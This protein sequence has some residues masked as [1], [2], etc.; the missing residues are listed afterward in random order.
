[1]KW[2]FRAIGLILF[3]FIAL[4]VAGFFMPAQQTIERSIQIDAYAEDIFPYINDLRNYAQWSPLSDVIINAQTIYGGADAGIGQSMAWQGGEGPFPYG[5]QEIIQSQTGDFVQ[6]NVNLAGLSALSTHAISVDDETETVT[7]L[8]KSDIDLGGF[9]YLG[10]IAG[11]LNQADQEQHF[12]E[13]L[14]RLKTIVE[15]QIQTE[16]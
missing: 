7:V 6:I 2:L 14:A 5:S 10:R 16:E 8:T 15:A 12:D 4:C 13:A 1:M 3:A 11:K 9:P